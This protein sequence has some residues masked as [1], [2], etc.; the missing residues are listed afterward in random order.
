MQM[1]KNQQNQ[2]YN[3][4]EVVIIPHLEENIS[5]PRNARAALPELT[6]EQELE[7]MVN[8]IKLMSDL[9][10]Q[11]IEATQEDIDEAKTVI[12]TIIKEPET[13]LQLKKYKNSVLA[14]LA[15]M[16]AE[17]DAQVV[18]DLKD[19]KTFV[20]NGL[21]KEAAT[22]EKSKERITAL[23]AI[24]EVDGVDAFKKTTEVIHKNMSLDDI[25]ER[26]R[27]LVTRIEKRI[28]EKEHNVIDAEIVKD[29]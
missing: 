10:G 7:M 14:S 25:E 20:V 16:V 9:T 29:E 23:R 19:L 6:N 5:L 2:T 1:Q 12:K 22:A 4:K 24:G 13:K 17:L 18:D 28:Q 21:I 3:G 27:T 11:P 15:G 8:T 26:L